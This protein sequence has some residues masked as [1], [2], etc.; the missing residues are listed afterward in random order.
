MVSKKLLFGILVSLAIMALSVSAIMPP[1]GGWGKESINSSTAENLPS[2]CPQ[3]H[4]ANDASTLLH[5]TCFEKNVLI[6]AKIFQHQLAIRLLLHDN[7]WQLRQVV[8]IVP[9]I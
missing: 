8:W 6:T 7:R 2:L 1:N 4:R 9:E 5:F 3:N